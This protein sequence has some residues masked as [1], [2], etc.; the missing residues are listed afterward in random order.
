MR[1]QK[2]GSNPDEFASAHG[3]IRSTFS[4]SYGNFRSRTRRQLSRDYLPLCAFALKFSP[5]NINRTY[6][7]TIPTSKSYRTAKLWLLLCAIGTDLPQ[8]GAATEVRVKQYPN[9]GSVIQRT[10]RDASRN[11]VMVINIERGSDCPSLDRT[12]ISSRLR[13]QG[14]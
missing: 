11:T 1:V 7:R 8:K 10:S 4:G 6:A 13:E 9:H 5:A 14:P 12:W 2:N 3:R